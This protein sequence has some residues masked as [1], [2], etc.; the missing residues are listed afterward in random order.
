MRWP[1]IT[2]RR[3]RLDSV[4]RQSGPLNRFLLW[5]PEFPPDAS[6]HPP[7]RD[8]RGYVFCG[9]RA[10]LRPGKYYAYFWLI[11]PEQ[12]GSPRVVLDAVSWTGDTPTTVGEITYEVAGGSNRLVLLLLQFEQFTSS[13][14]EVRMWSDVAANELVTERIEIRQLA[15]DQLSTQRELKIASSASSK[16]VK[17]SSAHKFEAIVQQQRPG[18]AAGYLCLAFKPTVDSIHIRSGSALPIELVSAATAA[19]FELKDGRRVVFLPLALGRREPFGGQ[20]TISFGR[21]TIHLDLPRDSLDPSEGVRSRP[22]GAPTLEEPDAPRDQHSPQ[23]ERLVHSLLDKELERRGLAQKHALR[24][25]ATGTADPAATGS[26]V[27]LR[28]W[29]SGEQLN[30]PPIGAW[31]DT[32][33]QRD[34]LVEIK[35]HA[36]VEFAASHNGFF[37]F[38]TGEDCGIAEIEWGYVRCQINLFERSR[39]ATIVFIPDDLRQTDVQKGVV[40][41]SGRRDDLPGA[42]ADALGIF[43]LGQRNPAAHSTDVA[44]KNLWTSFPFA[45]VAYEQIDFAGDV[46]KRDDAIVVRRGIGRFSVGAMPAVQLMRHD[47]GG[48]CVIQYRER[49]ITIDLYSREREPILVIPAAPQPILSAASWASPLGNELVHP[50]LAH[51]FR[52]MRP[53]WL[54]EPS[55]LDRR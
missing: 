43:A 4:G 42:G 48:L 25:R 24:L 53:A 51:V 11:V 23:L 6:Q 27:R 40:T 54:S 36:L 30:S 10:D 8:G 55:R 17:R 38:E 20:I 5:V 52:R 45:P 46:D 19:Q 2:P 32:G 31:P 16:A 49:L 41:L 21:A 12:V 7:R 15:E 1:S 14:V 39:G 22:S 13:Q 28:L 47:W 33:P 26:A 35:P 44:V 34:G 18:A 3:R 37:L 9:P 29:G 50:A